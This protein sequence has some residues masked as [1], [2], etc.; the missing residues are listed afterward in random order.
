MLRETEILEKVIDCSLRTETGKSFER[1]YFDTKLESKHELANKTE[2]LIYTLR[3]F[4]KALETKE[5]NFTVEELD[6]IIDVLVM[7]ADD[8]YTI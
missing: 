6:K 1:L 5:D 8:Y 2:E 7:K 4:A 3:A